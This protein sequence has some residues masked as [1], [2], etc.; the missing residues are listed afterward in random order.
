MVCSS[1]TA[2][3]CWC[4][5]VHALPLPISPRL[6]TLFELFTLSWRWC[7]YCRWNGWH[8]MHHFLSKPH[9][10]G[11]EILKYRILV[12]WYE[13]HKILA[14]FHQN[15]LYGREGSPPESY[16]LCTSLL[17]TQLNCSKL[18]SWTLC[19]SMNISVL[20]FF[21]DKWQ[22]D[23]FWFNFIKKIPNI[24]INY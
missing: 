23:K 20:V 15:M 9:L 2:I 21:F 11:G 18:F 8:K 4:M 5:F 10:I 1:V 13:W 16:C 17:I 14:Q 7:Y 22:R 6:Y 3:W 12:D 19:G 24:K